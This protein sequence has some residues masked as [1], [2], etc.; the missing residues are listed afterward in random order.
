MILELCPFDLTSFLPSDDLAYQ[1]YWASWRGQDSKV[2]ELLGKGADPNSSQSKD[3]RTPLMVAC[4]Y[5]HS[6]TAERLIKWGAKVDARNE[7]NMTALHYASY[8]DS[9]DCV[10]VL[11]AYGCPTGEPWWVNG[12]LADCQLI[13]MS[14]ASL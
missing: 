5:N 3:G 11:M 7:Y 4:R 12:L 8:N 1:L 10:R 2:L 14:V 6:L 13:Y 9:M